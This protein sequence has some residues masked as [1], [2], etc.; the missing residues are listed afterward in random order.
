MNAKPALKGRAHSARQVH[1]RGRPS[2]LPHERKKKEAT[3]K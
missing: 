2:Y 1:N 3:A